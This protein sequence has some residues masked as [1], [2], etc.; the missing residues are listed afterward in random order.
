M[1]VNSPAPSPQQ[2]VL[3]PLSTEPFAPFGQVICS[4]GRQGSAANQG[5]AIRYNYMANLQNLREHAKANLA[6]FRS[7][8]RRLPLDIVLLEKHPFSSQM[9]TPMICSSYVVIVAPKNPDLSPDL[10]KLRAFEAEPG[11]AVNYN[12]AVWHHPIIA[13]EQDAEFTMLAW[14]DGTGDDCIEYPLPQH[15]VL[16][17]QHLLSGN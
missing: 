11:Q 5:T 2:L 8:A 3:E 9:F 15:F 13:L 14:E 16:T 10:S 7:V 17:R 1:S 12:P 6:V 4:G